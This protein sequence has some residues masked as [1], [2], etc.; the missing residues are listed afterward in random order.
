MNFQNHV[1]HLKVLFDILEKKW[2]MPW[3]Y[4]S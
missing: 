2:M 3:K 1:S 4:L